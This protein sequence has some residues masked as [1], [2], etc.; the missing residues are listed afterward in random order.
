LPP[1]RIGSR[2]DESGDAASCDGVVVANFD[3]AGSVSTR[4]CENPLAGVPDIGTSNFA[5][6]HVAGNFFVDSG[7]L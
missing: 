6:E 1:F 3:S 5:F 7:P 2:A 4:G